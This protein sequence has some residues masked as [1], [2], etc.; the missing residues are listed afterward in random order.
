MKHIGKTIK[1]VFDRQP[2]SCTVSWFARRLHCG[3]ANIYDIFDR[4]TIDCELL[5]RISLVLGHNF[6]ADL[7]DEM[8]AELTRSFDSVEN[9][10]S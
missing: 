8:H 4:A 10:A 6:F 9:E 7:S 1:Q 3:R 2:R 5:S